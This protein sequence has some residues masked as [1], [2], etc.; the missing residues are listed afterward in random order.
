M[1][2]PVSTSAGF[3]LFFLVGL[4]PTSAALQEASP[5]GGVSPQ[6]AGIVVAFPQRD[7]HLDS[8]STL[9]V[10]VTHER[11]AEPLRAVAISILELD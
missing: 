2:R 9:D 8:A 6:D 3:A 1:R 10:R 4:G 7:V 11:A 5:G